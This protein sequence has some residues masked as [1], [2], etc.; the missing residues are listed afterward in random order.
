MENKK[1]K[2]LIVGILN[3]IIGYLIGVGVFK[4]L[5]TSFNIFIIS[6]VSSI[7]TISFSFMSYKFFVFKTKGDFIIEYLK[8]YL[9]YGSSMAISMIFLWIFIDIINISIWIAQALVILITVVF[10][11]Y[12]HSKFTFN[13]RL[14]SN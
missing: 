11:Y 2:Y 1:I 10:S 9:V 3:T 14:D 12:G 13:K 8:A 4:Y 5:E 6:I 7:F